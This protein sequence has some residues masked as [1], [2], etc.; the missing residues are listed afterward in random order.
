MQITTT[1]A[2]KKLDDSKELFL[3]LFKHG[4]LSVEVYKPV[5]ADFQTP[6]ERDEV[7]VIISGSGDFYSD[8]KYYP[9]K[10]GDFLF[11]AAG[12]G[13]RF[14][15]FTEDFSTWVIFYG[16]KGGEQNLVR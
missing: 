1:D 14:E 9:F 4:T 10:P 3:E 7:Y 8:G 15:K 2:L 11:V 12:V 5:G 13:H 6:H 16:P